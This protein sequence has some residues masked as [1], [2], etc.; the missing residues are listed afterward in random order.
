MRD[1]R[2]LA[3]LATYTDAVAD[4]L[5]QRGVVEPHASL[6]AE[7][8]MT[9]LRVAVEQWASGRDDRDLADVMRDSMAG[10]REVVGGG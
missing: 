10:L 5:H 8:G 4:V 2:E 6:A 3:K 7:A 1:Q 9:V